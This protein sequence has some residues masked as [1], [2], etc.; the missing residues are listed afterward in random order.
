MRVSIE[1][2][3]RLTANLFGSRLLHDGKE[4]QPSEQ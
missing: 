2:L 1:D 3:L 4:D